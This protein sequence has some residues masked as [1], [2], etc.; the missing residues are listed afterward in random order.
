MSEAPAPRSSTPPGSDPL[1]AAKAFSSTPRKAKP[2]SIQDRA[3]DRPVNKLVDIRIK[4]DREMQGLFVEVP[5]GDFQEYF[6]GGSEPP[7]TKEFKFNV[8]LKSEEKMYFGVCKGLED[9]LPDHEEF[10]VKDTGR[11]QDMAEGSTHAKAKNDKQPDLGIYPRHDAAVNAVTMPL[12]KKQ[13]GKLGR[14]VTFVGRVSWAWLSLSVE[15]KNKKTTAPFSYDNKEDWLPDNDEARKSR[16]QLADYAKEIFARQHRQFLFTIVVIRDRARISPE[17]LGGFIYRYATMTPVERGFDPTA[18]LARRRRGCM[19]S[20]ISKD[21][22]RRKDRKSKNSNGGKDDKDDLASYAWPI[23]RIELDAN[24]FVSV[25]KGGSERE[26]SD[27]AGED[28]TTANI[29]AQPEAKRYL[30]VGRAMSTS[31]SPTGRGT[32]GFAAYDMTGKTHVFLKDTW[33]PDSSC[34][35][36]EG[37]IYKELAKYEVADIATLL[38]CGDVGGG[39]PQTTRTQELLKKANTDMKILP[40]IH[41]RLVFEEIARPLQEYQNSFEMARAIYA[42]LT[43]HRQAW[44]TAGILHRDISDGNIMICDDVKDEYGQRISTAFLNDW[45]LAKYKHELAESPTQKTRSGTWQFISALLLKFP[46]KQ[47]EVSD[48]LESFIHVINWLSFWYHKNNYTDEPV[49]LG[50]QLYNLYDQCRHIPDG[51]DTGG[52][53]KFVQMKSGDPPMKLEGPSQAHWELLRSLASLAKEHYE[54]LSVSQWQ[55]DTHDRPNGGDNKEESMIEATVRL[56]T[57]RA[58]DKFV[59]K[60]VHTNQEDVDPMPATPPAPTTREGVL[61]SHGAI[62]AAFEDALSKKWKPVDKTKNFV[63]TYTNSGTHILRTRTGSGKRSA[64]SSASGGVE[65]DNRPSKKR[66]S[67]K[68]SKRAQ[69]ASEQGDQSNLSAV[70]EEEED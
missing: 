67:G 34:I 7:V 37:E 55:V 22:K 63:M 43:A 12:S 48:D 32:K 10:I 62:L 50:D 11:W 15:V 38:Y 65:G 61:S 9:S 5:D 49:D 57:K 53:G 28:D 68:R 23:Y 40:R 47:H 54:S 27:Q 2:S 70:P 6:P 51:C 52:N 17:K 26:N 8:D 20:I 24:E 16:G 19:N 39:T 36:A 35:H 66:R 25:K 14:R 4:Y 31:L 64:E 3:V 56:G 60:L 44:E 18:M 41:Y 59:P 46:Q 69:A 1:S 33:R 45:D 29:D 58:Y 13:K 42:A 30:L 21:P